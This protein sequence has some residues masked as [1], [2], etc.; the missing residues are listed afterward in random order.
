MSKTFKIQRYRHLRLDSKLQFATFVLLYISILALPVMAPS[1]SL[2]PGF[3]QAL[4]NMFLMTAILF[5]IRKVLVIEQHA[6][7][8]IKQDV[9]QRLTGHKKEVVDHID[10][11]F[12]QIKTAI[13]LA[14]VDYVP[15]SDSWHHKA[16]SIVHTYKASPVT[17]ED[18][19]GIFAITTF[20]DGERASQ[21]SAI[22]R[23]YV[24]EV[25]AICCDGN[26]KQ[27][28]Y[29]LMIAPGD[30][31]AIREDLQARTQAFD[32]TGW[33]GNEF[34]V[35]KARLSSIDLL[36][37]GDEI[38]F[39]LRTTQGA[40]S[41]R[42]GIYIRDKSISVLFHRWFSATYSDPSICEEVSREDAD[43]WGLTNEQREK[44]NIET[45]SACHAAQAVA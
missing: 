28:P 24:T 32:Q 5:V 18:R 16:I 34:Q 12:G 19:E 22:R 35:K 8:E 43:R 20:F 10:D 33:N 44:L 45:E 40:Q 3:E 15:D 39:S 31:E 2:Q 14:N 9:A 37:A 6:I 13:P 42:K 1:W 38:L 17:I 11:L 30:D 21:I 4:V 27:T 26:G 25:A 7:A 23:R 29:C 36:L 41:T